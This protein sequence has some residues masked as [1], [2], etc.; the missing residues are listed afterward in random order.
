[1]KQNK[2]DGFTLIE[3]LIT[4]F[5]VGITLAVVAE[6]IYI[7]FNPN[8]ANAEQIGRV[9]TKGWV[10][11]DG[12]AIQAF[13]DPTIKGVTCYTTQHNRALSWDDSSSTSIACRQTGKIDGQFKTR[14]NVFATTKGWNKTTVVDRFWDAKRRV[15]VYLTYTKG[16]EGKN[17]S[18]SI[19]VV[20]V[21]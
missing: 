12:L 7:F 20:V 17:T 13:D 11:K 5:L 9:E 16:A 6:V 10:F 4:L 14:P 15:L 18:H 21:Q 3:L 8:T 2:Q 1:M 19:S